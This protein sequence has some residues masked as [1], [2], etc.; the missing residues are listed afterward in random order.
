MV[1]NTACDVTGDK[2]E[3]NCVEQLSCLLY[4]L[5]SS[6]EAHHRV[7]EAVDTEVLQHALHRQPVDPERDA[8]RAEVQ[9]AA[10]HIIVSQ[11]VGER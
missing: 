3:A 7:K 10:D 9:T 5:D 8:A 2:P 6:R 11:Q 1:L 4:S